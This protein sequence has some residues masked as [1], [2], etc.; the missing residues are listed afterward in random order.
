MKADTLRWSRVI[1]V[2]MILLGCVSVLCGEPRT[3][4]DASGAFS[5][6]ADF[7]ELKDDKVSLRKADGVII[8]VPLSKLSAADQDAA[9]QAAPQ[10]GMAPKRP[11][12]TEEDG[13]RAP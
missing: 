7:V 2:A 1:G 11:V 12:M 4:K 8:S 5:T 9:R 6:L 10:N 3:W 13:L